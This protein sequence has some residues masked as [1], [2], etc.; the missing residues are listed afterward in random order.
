MSTVVDIGVLEVTFSA[1]GPS[2]YVRI[3]KRQILTYKEDSHT[4]INN[5][6]IM[7]VDHVD[8]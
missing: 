4:E 7:A 3:C 1:R 2:L 6:F 8:P 5:I